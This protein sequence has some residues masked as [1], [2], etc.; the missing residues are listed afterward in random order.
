ML[1][2]A[3]LVVACSEPG[4]SVGE[5][6]AG[7]NRTYVHAMDGAPYSI[8]PA[9]AN[10]IYANFLAVNL[11]DTLYRYR[12]LSRPYELTPNLADGMPQ[13]SDDGLTLTITLKRGVR[14]IDDPA[15]PDGQGRE[16]TAQDVVYS[17]QRHFDPQSRAQGAWLWQD[18]IEDLDA[19]KQRGSDY[20]DPV[21]GLSALDRHTLR[22]RLTRP[23]PQIVHTLAQGYAAVVPREAVAFHGRTL[24]AH[25][26]GSGPFRL[27][28]F[29]TTRAVLQRNPDFRAEALDLA[30]EGY[31][32]ERDSDFGLEALDGRAPPFLD[33]LVVEF[34][35]EDAARWNAFMSG[36]I[37]FMK[38]PAAQFGRVLADGPALR[39]RPEFMEQYRLDAAPEPGLV[40]THFNMADPRIGDHPDPAQA[41]RNR[42]LRCAIVN[43]FD[44]QA[45]NRMFFHGIGQVFPGILPPSLPEHDPEQGLDYVVHDPEGA[46]QLLATHGWTTDA[47]PTLEYGYPTSV[48]ERQMFDQFRGFM[49]DIGWPAEKVQPQVF[50]TYGDYSRAFSQGEVMLITTSWTLDYPD[51]ENVVQLFYGPNAAPGS[52]YSN[53]D[54]P[55]FN[56]LYEKGAPLPPSPERTR[57]FR[58]MNQR[59]MDECATISGLSR[60]LLL[61]WR[62]DLR[63]RPDRSNSLGGYFLRFVDT[64]DPA[65]Q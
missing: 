22:I 37:D 45:R 16:V 49:Q 11:Y 25:A 40:M 13:F 30:E 1:L 8:D 53:F 6:N 17:L 34:I 54:D 46:R 2:P 4:D 33:T 60:T 44:W 31:D 64:A 29:D 52:N 24:G 62:R 57:L 19:W 15:F 48:T 7:T 3:L 28:S 42:A 27:E 39:L 14:F 36:Q 65:T 63:M 18:R 43:G 10:S 21:S 26:V 5:R 50:A 51:A 32:A 12:Y 38:V 61:M 20:D 35:S 59:V 47:L 56:A 23:Y 9:Q 58:A 55:L 41:E